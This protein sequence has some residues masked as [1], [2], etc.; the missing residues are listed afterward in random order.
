ML[1][2]IV[3]P[4]R[5][6]FMGPRLQGGSWVKKHKRGQS[7]PDAASAPSDNSSS[8]SS[9]SN[10]S[11]RERATQGP[12]NMVDMAEEG[13]ILRGL[14]VANP[15]LTNGSSDVGWGRK[16]LFAAAT[17]GSSRDFCISPTLPGETVTLRV[18][19]LGPR[20]RKCK[21]ALLGAELSAP[22]HRLP[23]CPHFFQGCSGCQLLHLELAQQ[24]KA[25]QQ[26]LHQLLQELLNEQQQ[27]QEA[28]Q[29]QE[30]TKPLGVLPLESPLCEAGSVW[31]KSRSLLLVAVFWWRPKEAWFVWGYRAQPAPAVSSAC[32]AVFASQAHSDSQVLIRLRGL[33]EEAPRPALLQ[34]AEAFAARSANSEGCH[35]P[36]PSQ[37]EACGNSSVLPPVK[38]AIMLAVLDHMQQRLLFLCPSSLL[39]ADQGEYVWPLAACKE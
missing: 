39:R 29:S 26:L 32:G 10:S 15:E 16:H 14:K 33:L 35:I 8:S 24:L 17:R 2:A 3:A 36:R 38:E 31:E 27:H 19:G 28:Q 13:D 25:K 18:E 7:H 11:N 1:G 22:G 9:S 37:V 6:P 21:A 20:K 34:L 4:R 23:P 5:G 12:L 30:A